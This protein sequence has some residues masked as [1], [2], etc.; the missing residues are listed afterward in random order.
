MIAA[1]ARASRVLDDGETYLADARR[2]AD[3][4]RTRLWNPST[5]T[6]L[7]R[8]RK[9]EAGVEGYAE[10]Y[11]YLIFGLLELFQAD[12]DPRWLEWAWTLQQRQD[13]LFWDPIEGGWFSTTGRDESVLLR[14]KEDYDGAEPA[15]SSIGVLNLLTFAHLIPE[16]KA[17]SPEPVEEKI[18]LTL[19]VFSARA[20]QA[21]RTVPMMLAALSTY[22]AGI[23]Q[24]V[25]AGDRGAAD[26]KA[27]S[28]V[29]RRRY[30]PTT[31]V[32]PVE[33]GHRA[34]LCRVLSWASSMEQRD[35]RAT[36]YVCRNFACQLP[37]TAPS[38]LEGQLSKA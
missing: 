21:G 6:L 37:A 36:A 28:D 14:L 19:G 16:S 35:G 8:Y 12:G 27:L 31:V 33:P 30:L 34:A 3:F 20:A 18:D 11:A 25:L 7:R 17:Q 10:D 29:V 2:A 26:T 24:I 5:E 9:G 1:F 38:E 22:H 32:V 13:A 15:A 23:P 4:I